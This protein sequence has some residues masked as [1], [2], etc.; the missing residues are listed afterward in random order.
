MPL[1]TSACGLV[2][3]P[4]R[5]TLGRRLD[6]IAPQAEAQIQVWGLTLSLEAITEDFVFCLRKSF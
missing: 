2:R 5:R 1:V 4:D 3:L 6:K